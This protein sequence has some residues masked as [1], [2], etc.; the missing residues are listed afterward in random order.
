MKKT[1]LLFILCLVVFVL[2]V[3][4]LGIYFL[5][6]NSPKY[7][8]SLIFSSIGLI[9]IVLLTLLVRKFEKLELK[10]YAFDK[11]SFC[12]MEKDFYQS[13]RVLLDE[14]NIENSL[15][16]KNKLEKYELLAL[17]YERKGNVYIVFENEIPLALIQVDKNLKNKTIVFK[18]IKNVL[19]NKENFY[20]Q[21]ATLEGLT[22]MK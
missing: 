5:D 17:D 13:L 6:V 4:S 11:Y 2:F 7:L 16:E 15:E 1:K 21:I 9:V 20:E 19:E 14:S 12:P 10:P 8:A 3:C 22:L 18:E